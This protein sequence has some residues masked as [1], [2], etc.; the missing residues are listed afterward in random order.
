MKKTRSKNILVFCAALVLAAAVYIWFYPLNKGVLIISSDAVPYLVTAGDMSFEC[1]E[2]PCRLS[3]KTGFYNLEIK[4]DK[5]LT[6]TSPVNI[7]R[8]KTTE[9]SADLRKNPVLAVSAAIPPDENT[10][11]KSL[12]EKVQ[13]MSPANASWNVA[14][15]MLAFI[16]KTDNKLKILD[17]NGTIKT[18]TPLNNMAE[19]FRLYWSPD[20]KYLFGAEKNDIY[21]IDIENVA[22]KKMSIG[23]AP[24]NIKWF[25]AGSYLLVN[26]DEN[27]LYKIDIAKK[28][29]EPIAVTLPLAN[30]VWEK[31]GRLIFFTY[32]SSAKK[33]EIKSFDLNAGQE[34]EILAQ[35]N[36]SASKIRSDKDGNIYFY[37]SEEKTWYNLDY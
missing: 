32:D 28:T 14:E 21:F 1:A 11:Q 15:N 8:G 10:P 25:P 35:N 29:I 16:D 13:S 31:E 24:V 34:N 19:S 17:E 4:K 30:A 5:Y 6:E 3:L 23:F 37:N 22:R 2:T 18:V 26:D 36:F 7:L 33:T 27:G 9:I 20:N 12:P